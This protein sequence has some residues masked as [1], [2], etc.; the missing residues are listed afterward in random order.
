MITAVTTTNS[1]IETI[2]PE[3]LK[4]HQHNVQSPHI[5][6]IQILPKTKPK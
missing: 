4:I 3:H 5:I 2:Q 6:G 1:K